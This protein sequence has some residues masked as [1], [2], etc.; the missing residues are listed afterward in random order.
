[1]LQIEL[2]VNGCLIDFVDVV[3]VSSEQEPATYEVIYQ[4][5]RFGFKHNRSEGALVC[6][7]KALEAIEN[8]SPSQHRYFVKKTGKNLN[9]YVEGGSVS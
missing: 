8:E 7:K 4:G 6:A 1:M 2:K 5:K 3:N 9:K